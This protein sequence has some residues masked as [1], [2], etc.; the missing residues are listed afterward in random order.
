MRKHSQL[1]KTLKDARR[2]GRDVNTFDNRF[3]AFKLQDKQAVVT[4]S[5]ISNVSAPL[6]SRCDVSKEGDL[7]TKQT[8][9]GKM[10]KLTAPLS[11]HIEV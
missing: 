6:A 2:R 3:D 11:A 10:P 8:S 1:D 5:S 4:S 7:D 9:H